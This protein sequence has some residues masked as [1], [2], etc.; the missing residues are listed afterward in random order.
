MARKDWHEE[1][2]TREREMART[3]S[4]LEGRKYRKGKGKGEG[5]R[6]GEGEERFVVLVFD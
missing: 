6:E 3:G 1:R 5:R 4:V 2:G